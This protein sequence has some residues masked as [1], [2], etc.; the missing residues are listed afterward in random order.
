MAWGHPYQ[1]RQ[2]PITG[3]GAGEKS[4]ARMRRIASITTARPRSTSA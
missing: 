1:L 2:V 3:R 4:P